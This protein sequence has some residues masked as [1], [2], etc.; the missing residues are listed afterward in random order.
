LT[1]VI[2]ALLEIKPRVT[3]RGERRVCDFMLEV[4][5]IQVM[6]SMMTLFYVAFVKKNPLL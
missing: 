3:I 2:T 4:K 6:L 5:D 1:K